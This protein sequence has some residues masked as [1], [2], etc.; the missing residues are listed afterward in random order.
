VLDIPLP[1]YENKVLLVEKN[2]VK[3]PL[4]KFLVRNSGE[5]IDY[6]TLVQR[7]IMGSNLEHLSMFVNK[8][9]PFIQQIVNSFVYGNTSIAVYNLQRTINEVINQM[10]VHNTYMNS[11]AMNHRLVILDSAFEDLH[12]PDAKLAYQLDKAD[13][14]FDRGWTPM[15]LSDGVLADKNYILTTDLRKT[16]PFGFSHHNP[17]RNLYSTL[18]MKGPEDS[19]VRTRSMDDLRKDGLNRKG[20]NLFTAFADV[21]EV[22]EDQ[23]LLDNSLRNHYI[24]YHRR[25]LGFGT[26]MVKE[27]DIIK[28]GSKICLTPDG[29][30]KVI[31][32]DADKIWIDKVVQKEVVVGGTKQNSITFIVKFNRKLKE[33]VKITNRAANKGVIRF[34]DL[35]WA[36]CNGKRRKIQVLVSS[37]AVLKRK[38][39]TQILEALMNNVTGEKGAIIEDDYVPNM[40]VVKNALERTGFRRDGSWDC[41]TYAGKFPAVCGVVFWGVTMDV[42]DMLWDLHDTTRKNTRG[43]RTAGLK[44]STVE[45]RAL[46]TRFGKDNAIA[47]EIMSY[48]QGAEDLHEQIKILKS[49]RGD[50]INAS[51]IHMKHVRPLDDTSGTIVPEGLIEGTIADENLGRQGFLM[52]LPSPYQV[53]LDGSE[54]TYEGFPAVDVEK[55][56]QEGKKVVTLSH[57]YVPYGNLR[58]CWRHDT[59]YLGMTTI[60]ALLNSMIVTGHRFMANPADGNFRAS[61][62]RS[63]YAYFSNVAQKMGSK[64][65]E[66]SVHGMAVRYPFSAKAVATL[67]CEL[68]K[69]TVQIH[70]DMA[71]NL[72]VQ[73]G[74]VVLVE[75]FPCLGFM[76]LRPQRV[77]V[78]DD[79]DCRYSIRVSGNNLGSL[80]LDFDGDVIYLASF[81]TKEAKRALMREFHNPNKTCY[82]AI[83]MLNEKMGTPHYKSM[84]FDDYHMVPFP[85]LTME[86]HRAIVDKATGVKAHTGP[87]I[88]LCYNIMRLVEN[89][90]TKNNQKMNVAIEMFLDKVGNS[91][92]KQKHGVKSLHQVVTEAI[93]KADVETLVKEGFKRGTSEMICDLIRKKAA[94]LKVFDLAKYHERAKKFGSNIISR[95]VRE[96]NKIYFASRSTLEGCK[97]LSHLEQ[98]AV[99]V[100]SRMLK[101]VL[102]GKADSMET[103]LDRMQLDKMMSS[104]NDASLAEKVSVMCEY[105]DEIFKKKETQVDRMVKRLLHER[106][107]AVNI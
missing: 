96:Q 99:D 30:Y 71:K 25:V 42:E 79:P 38:N 62:Y 22:W 104:I 49:K 29:Q 107:M 54:V 100:P 88:A 31:E 64:T 69:N 92:F 27:G 14:Y 66:I 51:V 82:D 65:G 44:F 12:S 95:L 1:F 98:A 4:C 50:K 58:R 11:W 13:E 83:K 89:S 28:K 78:T 20:W 102:S 16:I 10:P 24:T 52:E 8:K 39:Y 7:L 46:E 63:V 34:K 60:A 53:V 5:Q 94:M 35:G 45:F 48:A 105:M 103:V 73:N 81:H 41:E 36:E 76:S 106:N 15:G 70:R 55:E 97:L 26:P 68:P 67:S 85:P 86:T 17:Q 18:G 2:E 56:Q 59:G 43:L 84:T 90:D 32:F 33:G 80:S 72:R 40:E 21:P 74:D 3:R 77:V 61:Y 87:V 19:L 23:I 37:K 91:V 93:C 47:D 9:L 57:V 101:W 6:L 75:R